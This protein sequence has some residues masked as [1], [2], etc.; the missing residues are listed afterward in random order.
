M[1]TP[2]GPPSGSRGVAGTGDAPD[3]GAPARPG[4]ASTAG[5]L[6]W[7]LLGLLLLAGL[8]ARW[9]GELGVRPAPPAPSAQQSAPPASPGG[10]VDPV[11]P[12]PSFGQ[13]GDPLVIEVP[14]W[15]GPTLVAVAAAVVAAAVI[16]LLRRYL[17]RRLA[18]Y[19]GEVIETV[20]RTTDAEATAVPDLTESLTSARGALD[21]AVAPRD[22]VVA[23]WLAL[24]EGAADRHAARSPSQTPTEFTLELLARTH[25][26]P[27]AVEALRRT[28]L[29]A[30]FSTAPVTRQQVAVAS[31]ALARI[32]ATWRG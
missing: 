26:D 6:G 13:G 11:L 9:R 18:R 8:G 12:T 15:L 27:A 10:V 16:L 20:G 19:E 23:A 31:E 3:P 17:P 1:S 29:A 4:R 30:R 7:T 2:T 22:A 24:E 25:A 28:Y 32:E 21:R 14:D 5:R